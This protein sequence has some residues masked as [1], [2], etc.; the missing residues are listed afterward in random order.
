MNIVSKAGTEVCAARRSDAA[1]LADLIVIAGDGLPLVLWEQMREG[2]ETAMD[3][4]RRRAKR[5][6]GGFSWQKSDV[7]RDAEDL[8]ISALVSYPLKQRTPAPDIAQASAVFRPLLAL[9]NLAVGTWYINVL[10]TF[11][12]AR[13]QGAATALLQHAETRARTSG[14][15]ALSLITGDVNPAR[16]LYESLGFVEVAREEI[17]KSG[18]SYDG[19]EWLLYRK[20][21]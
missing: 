7:V 17:V 4:G 10:A 13:G 1:A 21:V 12:H 14:Y 6:A 2:D 11:E 19:T 18:W 8:V 20:P 9:E 16:K 5:D 3:V 15:T